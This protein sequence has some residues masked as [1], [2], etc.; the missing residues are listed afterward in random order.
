MGGFLCL[1]FINVSKPVLAASITLQPGPPDG[2]DAEIA[3]GVLSSSRN[4]GNDNTLIANRAGN[5]RSIG[6]IEFDIGSIPKN[7]AV[8]SA[9]LSLYHRDNPDLGS[10]Y[11]VFR[12]T[13]VWDEATVTFD[14]APTFHPTAVDTMIIRDSRLGFREWD[15]TN[16]VFGWLDGTYSNFGMWIEEIPVGGSAVAFFHSSDFGGVLHRPKLSVEYVPLP[17]AVWLFGSGL[18]GLIGLARREIG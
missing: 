16:L 3:D 13:S 12:V 8:I 15:V 14:T 2:K 11:D 9:T 1:L 10:R 6:L 5:D 4:Y 18:I 17:A 7:A